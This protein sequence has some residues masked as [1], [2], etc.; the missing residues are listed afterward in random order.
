MAP[1]DRRGS[2]LAQRTS[3][4]RRPAVCVGGCGKGV[5]SFVVGVA[6]PDGGYDA[7]VL[8]NQTN[9]VMYA[10]RATRWDSAQAKAAALGLEAR[11]IGL[12]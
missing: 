9:G 1:Y 7:I 12:L 6:P 8:L 5:E 11:R 2:P 10:V 3:T 4:Q